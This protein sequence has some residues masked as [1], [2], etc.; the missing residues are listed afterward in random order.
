MAEE[1]SVVVV[2][3]GFAG[4]AAA[5]ELARCGARVRVL[6]RSARPGGRA[7]GRVVEGFTLEPLAP[8]LSETDR[9]LLGWVARVGTTDQ[10]LPLR[11]MV[12]AH[13]HRGRV[14]DLEL[15]GLRDVA[16]IP[17][18]R[19]HHGLRLLRLPRLL[20]RYGERID[21]D[22]P[23]RAAP[24]DDRSL[25]DF[26]RLYF[27]PSVVERWMAPL[28]AA[29]SLADEREA[30]RALFLRRCRTGAFARPGL[31]RG[32]LAEPL[33]AAAKK[34]GTATGVEVT[35]L[36]ARSGGGL[37][38]R[39]REDQRA[40]RVAADAVVLATPPAEALR[41]AE[42]VLESAECDAL[43]RVQHAP[44]LVVAAA[45]LRPL[46][47]HPLLVRVP[48]AEGSPLAAAILE[49]GVRGGRVPDR[50]GLVSLVATAAFAESARD[51]PD[52]AL[53]KELVDA[54]ERFR[55]GL[56]S[57][58]VFTRVLRTPRAWPRFDV[59]HYRTID[60]LERLWPE[61][62]RDGRRLYLAGDHLVDPSWSGAY[63]SGL[64]AA[65]AVAADLRIGRRR[66]APVTRPAGRR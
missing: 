31:P 38:V 28:L 57:A 15:R 13:V 40:G 47:L 18:V 56:R 29:T 1:P 2:G 6:E 62:R 59:G 8:I 7:T 16:R 21:P 36:E 64:R 39:Y 9:G 55:P 66:V 51:V 30:S 26:G 45:T 20:S 53:E 32:P 48:R 52:D 46:S 50:C 54:F 23:E 4:L 19:R 43:A 65:R 33:E 27:G 42:P 5:W 17:G 24:L 37:E 49:P 60:R 11:P 10:W 12:T 25:A 63:D 14:H 22:A 58:I 61:L 34:L 44:A 41:I 35:Q 3:A